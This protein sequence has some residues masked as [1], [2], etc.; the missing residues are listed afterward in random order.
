MIFHPWYETNISHK[1][2]YVT[3]F[4]SNSSN[5]WIQ[6]ARDD[7]NI[8]IEIHQCIDISLL[9]FSFCM[10]NTNKI[11]AYIIIICT[12]IYFI[13]FWIACFF[14]WP[15][16]FL[17]QGE[18]NITE[19]ETNGYPRCIK[20]SNR[21][22]WHLSG[23]DKAESIADDSH[24]ARVTP[25]TQATSCHITRVFCNILRPGLIMCQCRDSLGW[26]RNLRLTTP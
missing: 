10:K 8:S 7:N 11:T 19:F 26:K 6:C 4:P 20:W 9:L 5:S 14:R 2:N 3:Y 16:K 21:L 13:R 22:E 17:P 23:R 24:C 1:R 12:N 25:P 18:W 15:W